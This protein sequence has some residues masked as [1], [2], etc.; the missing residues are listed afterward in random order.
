YYKESSEVAETMQELKL[1]GSIAAKALKD[2]FGSETTIAV[3]GPFL[4]VFRL[5]VC[6][7]SAR[8]L[9]S[10]V[11]GSTAAFAMQGPGL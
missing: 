8:T 3:Q 4:L 1:T 7:C 9:C 6:I 5:Y 10:Q 2:V 11:F